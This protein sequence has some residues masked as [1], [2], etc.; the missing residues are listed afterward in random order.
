[1]FLDLRRERDTRGLEQPAGGA[2]GRRAQRHPFAVLFDLDV[3]E[4]VE[5]APHVVPFGPEVV[6]VAAVGELLLEH[7]RQERAEHVATDRRIGLMIDRAGAHQRLGRP[8]QALDL[9]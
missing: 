3:L 4:P 6:R 1:M 9:E 8:E 5:I 7:E 2:G